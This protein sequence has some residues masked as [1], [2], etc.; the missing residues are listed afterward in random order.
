MPE[1]FYCFNNQRNL[2]HYQLKVN[3]DNKKLNLKNAS[4]V[5]RKRARI[6]I[7]NTIYEF[8]TYVD[9]IKLSPFFLKDQ[10]IITGDKKNEYISKVIQP[11]VETNRVIPEGFEIQLIT[12]ITE[13]ILKVKEQLNAQQISL[14]EEQDAEN[15]A[16]HL[17]FELIFKYQD[18][19][20]WAGQTG[21]IS[22]LQM[23]DDD[24][25]TVSYVQRD[26]GTEKFYIEEIRKS[27]IDLDGK[28]RKTSYFEGIEWLNNHVKHI[29]TLGVNI[30]LQRKNQEN[31]V[32]FIG[33]REITIHLDEEKDWFDIRGKVRFG[34]FEIPLM[35]VLNYMKRNKRMIL[36]P[37]G[38]YAQIP[39][40]WF[41]E[42]LPL[43]EFSKLENGQA[44]FPK[45]YIVIADK[46]ST[47]S[48]ISITMKD[49]LRK[50]LSNKFDADF[51]LPQ[52]FHGQLRH[53][54]QEGYNWLR[55]LDDLGLGGCLADDMGLGKTIQALCLI[56]WMKEN[57]RGTNLLVVPTSLVYNWQQE[58]SKFT[59]D[60]QIF[61]HTG[62]QRPKSTD[63]FGQPDILLTSYAIL[64]RDKLLF[65]KA[66]FNYIILD[67]AQA[68]KNPQSDIAQV[69]F[70]LKADRF[71]TLTGTPI[72]NSLSDLWTQ[73]H[74]FSRN[75]LGSLNSFNQS[76]KL[77]EKLLLY[78][79][80][81]KP[82]L[83]R[84][85]KKD[86][87][88]DLPEKT[89]I[90]Q[91]CDMGEEQK[92]FYREL[93]NAYRDKFL[94]QKESQQKVNPIVL[95][96]GLLRLRQ[97]A[98]HPFLIDKEFTASTG[99]FDSVVQM[100]HDV[101]DQ[102][103]KVLIFS[104]FVEHLKLFRQYLQEQEIPFCYLD[105]STKNRAEQVELFQHNEQYQVFLL[106]LKAGGTGLNLTK[107]NYVFLLDP[108][109]NPAAEMQAFDRAHRI[110]QQ[111]NVFV[112]KFITQDSIE[113]KIQ[114]LQQEKL[115]LSD[116]MLEQE[117]GF[118][119]QM[120]VDEVMKLID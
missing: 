59:P 77:P 115:L 101:I 8:D 84:R 46:L 11:L 4:L 54:Q 51:E 86:V 36:L 61:V 96:E 119:H 38:E 82:F 44:V 56:Q 68:I 114:K 73:V 50:L 107:A 34:E 78:R 88:K 39:Q 90:I 93:R 102:G 71:L 113:E 75:M 25:F 106:S 69:C 117:N 40:A 91:P 64:R 42:Y 104:T 109:W 100:M 118:I 37:N 103:D 32:F 18:F 17:L 76:C 94:E 2:I 58:A 26:F 72:E 55:L 20:Y 92:K 24:D 65:E 49:S 9:G 45:Q 43:A 89:I 85:H 52:K 116:S 14:F 81:L 22:G 67:E 120:D 108:W 16:Q 6:L 15:K 87:L 53:Y 33:E 47:S 5:S 112:Y 35:L 19:S 30:Q 29:E 105:G 70:T 1:L 98:N 21:K 28:I 66:K 83:L 41:D 79:Q 63:E 95:L 97:A 57:G 23:H 31:P 80:L 60:L 10:I 3:F 111:K 99:K 62:S 74:F 27:G 110:G 12:E 13:V 48:G 7:K